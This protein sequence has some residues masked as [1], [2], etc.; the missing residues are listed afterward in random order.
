MYFVEGAC[1]LR[2]G[3]IFKDFEDPAK[4]PSAKVLDPLAGRIQLLYGVYQMY[5]NN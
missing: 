3:R 5:V 1:S 2:C 4:I